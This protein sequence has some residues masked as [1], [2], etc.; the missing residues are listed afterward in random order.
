M[1]AI[2]GWG[3]GLVQLVV[4]LWLL[5]DP[6]SF[7]D[8]IP[9]VAETGPFN[10]HFMNDTGC[11]FLVAGAGLVAC[12]C[13]ARARSA[14]FAGASF[15]ALHALVHIAD[16]VAGREAFG[17]LVAEVPVFAAFALVGFWIVATGPVEGASHA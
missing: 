11:A 8:G 1:R 17:H 4:G 12:V 6:R 7:Y 3:L 10:H 5:L 2:L 13:D 15:L 14:G 9:G 16:G